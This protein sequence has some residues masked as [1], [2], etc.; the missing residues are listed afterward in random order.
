MFKKTKQ[1]AIR[2]GKTLPTKKGHT[3]STCTNRHTHNTHNHT[4]KYIGTL[5]SSQTTFAP[6]T[7]SNKTIS[8]RRS[9]QSYPTSQPK[10]NQKENLNPTQAPAPTPRSDLKKVT[11]T[12]T[13]TQ[14]R[15]STASSNLGLLRSNS[16]TPD[17]SHKWAVH[18]TVALPEDS[19]HRVQWCLQSVARHLLSV[20]TDSVLRVLSGDARVVRG[21]CAPSMW[22]LPLVLA[23]HK[24][25]RTGSRIRSGALV[26]CAAAWR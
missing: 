17:S 16:R 21:C 4:K 1:V 18:L 2:R 15:R 25:R 12:F 8:T 19:V 20:I 7:S 13:N 6:A 9:D 26:A 10:S 24:S 5:L 14:T 11:H 22:L 3:R 23:L